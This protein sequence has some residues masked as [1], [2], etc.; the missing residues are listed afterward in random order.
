M[1]VLLLASRP[2][3]AAGCAPSDQWQVTPLQPVPAPSLGSTCL[4]YSDAFFVLQCFG[5]LTITGA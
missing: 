2:C 3:T 1:V 5:I 4:C